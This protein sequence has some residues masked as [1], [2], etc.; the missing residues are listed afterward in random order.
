M[1]AAIRILKYS[2]ICVDDDVVSRTR[3]IVLQRRAGHEYA[4]LVP[5]CAQALGHHR[6]DAVEQLTVY[7]YDICI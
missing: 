7:A 1:Y 3:G 5:V 2:S 6:A 4:V